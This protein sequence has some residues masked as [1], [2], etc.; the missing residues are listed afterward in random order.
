MEEASRISA[1]EAHRT[2]LG[3]DLCPS[4]A[5]PSCNSGDAGKG[6]GSGDGDG[7]AKPQ[8]EQ[9]GVADPGDVAE[10]M[11]A[12]GVLAVLA[13]VIAPC[14]A[15]GAPGGDTHATES[16]AESSL[17]APDSESL[18][19]EALEAAVAMVEGQPN[20]QRDF[21]R[22]GGHSRICSLVHDVAEREKQSAL[23]LPADSA[24]ESSSRRSRSR[25]KP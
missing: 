16:G 20:A 8:K 21:I 6:V 4:V 10:M 22:L 3:D 23:H 13:D 12:D 1:L 18:R 25:S 15:E 2:A 9:A 17:N 5:D 24:A 11:L 7:S 14:R 19:L